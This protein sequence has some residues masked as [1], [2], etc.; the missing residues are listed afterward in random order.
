METF[1]KL[2]DE[3]VLCLHLDHKD[4]PIEMRK[5]I[6]TIHLKEDVLIGKN[7]LIVD[8]DVR[9]L[10]ALTTAFERYHINA[11]TA[12]SG[13]E[14]IGI[15]QQSDDIDVILMDIMMP[16]MDGYETMQKIRNEIVSDDLPIIAVTAK[17]MMGDRQKCLEAGASDYIT[18]PVR[19]DQLLS[20]IRVWLN[21]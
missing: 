5:A 11:I 12:E 15:L 13:K 4:L 8:D 19:V 20:L 6:E 18:K 7:V 10:F 1:D 14:A 21:K 2:V 3:I 16:E 9:N 17:A